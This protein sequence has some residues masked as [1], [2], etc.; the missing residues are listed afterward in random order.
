MKFGFFQGQK[1]T[2]M[3]IGLSG[4]APGIAHFFLRRGAFVTA[5]DL[6]GRMELGLTIKKLPRGVRLVL[7]RH[8]PEDFSEA[9]WVIKNPAVP[10]NSK[11]ISIAER[12]GVPVLT[13]VGI[14]FLG[15]PPSVKVIGI[16]GTKGKTST[17][18]MIKEALKR[19]FPVKLVGVPGTSY[20]EALEKLRPGMIVVAELSSFDL[21]GLRKVKRSPDI[22][23]I[24]NIARDHLNRYSSMKDY[25][26]AKQAIFEFQ[27]RNGFVVANRSDSQVR[28]MVKN[29]AGR[30]KWFDASKTEPLVSNVNA[31]KEVAKI[32]GIPREA[33]ERVLK[34]FRPLAG[35]LQVVRHKGG[36]TV[37]NDTAATNPLAARTALKTVFKIYPD[38]PVVMILGGKD[39]RLD[40][41]DLLPEIRRIFAAVL[42]PGDAAKKI[43]TVLRRANI[44]KMTQVKTLRDA[45][46]KA[47]Y[48]CRT[49][50]SRGVVLF[51]P[52]AASFNMFKNEFERGA[53][54]I[55]AVKDL[56]G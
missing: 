25:I 28:R 1:I 10:W 8:R 14:F 34:S 9:D 31:A 56:Y 40:F 26:R 42:L 6:R 27:N 32:F 30:I 43:Y 13:D 19:R 20:L 29:A 21:E 16:T 49:A 55:K 48:F 53:E 17:A 38:K 4:R 2:I 51:S 7:G 45:L 35:H 23:V 44:K 47:D 22:A 41:S 18:Y 37:I 50:G 52:A 36:I 5:T 33:T 46:R 12:S 39:K 11:F 15:L 3:G 24:T 54:F